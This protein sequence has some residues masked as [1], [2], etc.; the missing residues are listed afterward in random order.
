LI[1]WMV[2]RPGAATPGGPCAV[3]TAGRYGRS[4]RPCREAGP[5]GRGGAS[6]PPVPLPRVG[7][8]AT[9]GG[10]LLMPAGWR[11]CRRWGRCGA[12]WS[13]WAAPGCRL[14]MGGPSGTAEEVG[15]LP[16]WPGR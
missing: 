6:W 15:G 9:A 14:S 1:L 2:A 16:R 8:P 12:R 10:R 3:R 7:T 11:P 4:V 5:D 13:S